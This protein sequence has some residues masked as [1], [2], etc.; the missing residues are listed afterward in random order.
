ME[1]SA[2]RRLPPGSHGIPADVVARNQRERLIAGIAEACAEGGYAE[3][4]VADA[5]KRAGVSTATF[6]EQFAGKR[7]CLLTAHGQL[8]ERLLEEVDRAREAESAG[9]EKSRAALRAMLALLEADPPSARLLTVEVLA[10]GLE[11][12]EHHDALVEALGRRLDAEWVPVAGMLALIGKLVMA[13]E[14]SRLPSLEDELAGTLSLQVDPK[15]FIERDIGDS[16]TFKL[17]P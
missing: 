7:D 16:A 4:S 17:Q 11:G 10:A 3:T 6:Y 9:N 12:V 8:L 15:S 14:A 1:E 5:A 2:S 13:G